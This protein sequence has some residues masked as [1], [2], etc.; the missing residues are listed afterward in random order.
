LEI[1]TFHTSV[2]NWRLWR[3]CRILWCSGGGVFAFHRH[4]RL[5]RKLHEILLACM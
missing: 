5:L 1:I 2:T 3:C 4:S